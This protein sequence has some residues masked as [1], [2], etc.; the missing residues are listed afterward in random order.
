[1]AKARRGARLSD[2][3]RRLETI[4]TAVVEVGNG[5]PTHKSYPPTMYYDAQNK[6]LYVC[7][8]GSNWK[9]LT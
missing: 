8:G 4:E 7:V 6:R 3:I 2:R 1:M 5:A 9:E